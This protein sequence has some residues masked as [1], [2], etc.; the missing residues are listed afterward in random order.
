MR[1]HRLWLSRL[2]CVPISFSLIQLGRQRQLKPPL[3]D[4]LL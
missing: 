1:D 3:P 4:G 2:R